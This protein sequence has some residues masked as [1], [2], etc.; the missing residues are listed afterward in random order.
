MM[1]CRHQDS[2]VRKGVHKQAE[3]L[4]HTLL[5]DPVQGK[6][7][8]DEGGKVPTLGDR[9]PDPTALI[10]NLRAPGAERFLMSELL[11]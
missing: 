8:G 3:D 10:V 6:E 4:L 7:V 1:K 11:V 2:P 5:C 9:G